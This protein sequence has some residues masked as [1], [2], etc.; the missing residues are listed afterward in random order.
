M[1][2]MVNRLTNFVI[3]GKNI[4]HKMPILCTNRQN[5]HKYL[6]LEIMII[7]IPLNNKKHLKTFKITLNLACLKGKGTSSYFFLIFP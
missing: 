6:K 1:S 2:I 4:K 5:K 7:Q 3:N